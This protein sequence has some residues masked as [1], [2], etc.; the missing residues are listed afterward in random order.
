M[1]M[2]GTLYGFWPGDLGGRFGICFMDVSSMACG[3]SSLP[4]WGFSSVLPLFVGR[5][6]AFDQIHSLPPQQ[7]DAQGRVDHVG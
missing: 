3:W 4:S 2:A 1:S 7:G 5:Y 6:C